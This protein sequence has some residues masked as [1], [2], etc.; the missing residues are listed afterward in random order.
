MRR[1]IGFFIVFL[2][3]IGSAQAQ[4]SAYLSAVPDIP[5][6]AGLEELAEGTLIFDKPQGRI[7]QLTAALGV[8]MK[9]GDIRAFYVKSLPNLGWQNTTAPT[10]PHNVLTF[11]RK[12]EILRI[13]FA[14]DLVI[15]DLVPD[16]IVP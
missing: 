2:G 8:D 11:A 3:L 7:V 14:A 4:N 1:L 5:L 16:T 15:F 10:P 6:A 13:T 12:G 9:A